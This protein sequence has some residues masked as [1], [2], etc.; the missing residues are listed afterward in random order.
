[1]LN[2]ET[3]AQTNGSAWVIFVFHHLCEAHC[4]P[5]VISPAKFGAFLAFLQA[6]AANGV[7][8]KTVAGVMDGG[9]KGSCDPVSGSGCDTSPR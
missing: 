6:E 8:V 4:G 1:V 5:Y 7:V 9:V 2:A 3:F